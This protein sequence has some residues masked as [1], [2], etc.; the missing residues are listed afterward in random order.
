MQQ[1][2][3]NII[4]CKQENLTRTA[5]GQYRFRNY[6]NSTYTYSSR[7][8]FYNSLVSDTCYPGYTKAIAFHRHYYYSFFIII[9]YT[10]ALRQPRQKRTNITI[11]N[12]TYY[13]RAYTAWVDKY[14]QLFCLCLS[15]ALTESNNFMHTLA[16]VY[17]K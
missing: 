14:G 1:S 4:R 15:K 10:Y 6:L 5:Y 13:H 7:F 17:D 9:V 3:Q 2:Y 11:Y 16:T 8:Y 12:A